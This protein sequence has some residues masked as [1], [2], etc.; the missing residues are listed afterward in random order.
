[1][2]EELL[3]GPQD[4]FEELPGETIT[5]AR[6]ASRRVIAIF[7]DALARSHGWQTIYLVSPWISTFSEKGLMT[8]SQLVKRLHDDNATAYVVTRPP[9]HAWH[10]QAI[11]SIAKTGKANIVTVPRLHTK[12]YCAITSQGSFAMLGSANFTRQSFSNREI[13]VFMR[14]SGLGK[15]LVRDLTYEAA[16]IYRSSPNRK[17]LYRRKF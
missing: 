17:V 15:K 6:I 2:A 3:I 14:G 4:P 7:V 9:D 16:E 5:W 12:L 10:E 8:F 11:D 1:M 13:G